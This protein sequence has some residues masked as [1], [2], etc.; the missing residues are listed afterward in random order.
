MD[1]LW[2]IS[3]GERVQLLKGASGGGACQ[4][5]RMS[6]HSWDVHFW[7]FFPTV[8]EARQGN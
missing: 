6:E 3:E 4:F 7:L 2:R 5:M 8:A 1:F